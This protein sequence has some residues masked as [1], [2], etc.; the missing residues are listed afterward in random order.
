MA[1][2][3]GGGRLKVEFH[4]QGPVAPPPGGGSQSGIPLLGPG[5]AALGGGGLLGVRPFS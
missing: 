4:F 3:P 2:P 5:G 1:R